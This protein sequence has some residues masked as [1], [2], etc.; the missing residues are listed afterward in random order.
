VA[1][2]LPAPNYCSDKHIWPVG[3]KSTRLYNS[4]KD[5]DIKVDYLCEILDGGPAGP[6]FKV[7]TSSACASTVVCD[8][9][10]CVLC[11]SPCNAFP[12][13]SRLWTI[14]STR[15]KATRL[16]VCGMR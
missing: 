11:C 8:V 13:R 3:F 15:W 2:R 7:R 1:V 16:A 4:Y 6:V 5:V 10:R 14:P 9:D 12:C